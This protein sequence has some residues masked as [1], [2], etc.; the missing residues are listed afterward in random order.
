MLNPRE[1]STPHRET[2]SEQV[3]DGSCMATPS[4]DLPSHEPNA[5]EGG[6]ANQLSLDDVLDE[7]ANDMDV[8]SDDVPQL[9]AELLYKNLR[10]R[11]CTPDEADDLGQHVLLKALLWRT[12]GG[13]LRR[14]WRMFLLAAGRNAFLDRRRRP[15]REHLVAAIEDRVAPEIEPLLRGVDE[16]EL[17]AA[18][19]ELPPDSRNIILALYKRQ[20]TR[21][22][23]ADSLR[24]ARGT[25][26]TQEGEALK[27]LRQLL[28]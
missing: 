6:S 12:H 3:G 24:C 2:V 9:L 21:V 27:L 13:K 26:R 20:M 14:T 5:A 8:L 22:E 19:D 1:E 4:C 17:W 18:V 23:F 11:G 28:Q 15:M 16:K 10:S 25:L 7:I